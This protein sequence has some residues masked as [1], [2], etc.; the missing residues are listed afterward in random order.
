MDALARAQVTR[1]ERKA[2][3]RLRAASRLRSGAVGRDGAMVG[4]IARGRETVVVIHRAQIVCPDSFDGEVA[5]RLIFN[6]I[7]FLA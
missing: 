6:L 7:S 4:R 2:V 3:E 5:S 1:R